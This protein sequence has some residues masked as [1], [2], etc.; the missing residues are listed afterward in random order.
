MDL[1]VRYCRGA[2]AEVQA[3]I[4]GGTVACLAQQFLCLDLAPVAH[5][6]A[7]ADRATVAFGPFEANLEPAVAGG[8]VVT[9]QGGPLILVHDQDVQ[10]SVVVEVAK[11]AA[12]AGMMGRHGCTSFFSELRKL[13]VPQVAEEHRLAARGKLREGA[14]E[15]RIDI[16]GDIE[17]V[18]P[19]VIIEIGDCSAPTY[20]AALDTDAR[21]I[22]YVVELALA[23]VV[24]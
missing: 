4:I 11:G 22:G 20:K 18:G 23:R 9:K 15:L 21:G 13:A 1:N 3:R 10:V 24:I 5:Q 12:A 19:T 17:D 8:R 14:F 7:R 6:H 16:A 2:K